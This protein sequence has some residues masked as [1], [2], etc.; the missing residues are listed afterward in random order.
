LEVI[1]MW[2]KTLPRLAAQALLVTALSLSGTN[3]QTDPP[4]V[5]ATI[6]PVHSLVAAVMKGIGVPTL[7]L[8]GAASPHT[9][10]LRPSDAR[11]LH[12]ARIIFWI[13]PSLEGFLTRSLDA[14]SG[15]ARVVTLL[16][17]PGMDL[18]AARGRHHDGRTGNPTWDPHLWLNPGNAQQ[19][20][21]LVADALV[22]EDPQNAEGYRRNAARAAARLDA[23]TQRI[24]SQFT[25]RPVAPF[26]LFHDSFQYLERA[27]GLSAAGFV[28]V[29]PDRPPGARHLGDIHALI[30]DA[31]A[32]CVFTEPQFEPRLVSTLVKGT[33]ARIAVLDALGSGLQAG[34]GLYFKMMENNLDAMVGCLIGP[35]GG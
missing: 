23:L 31:K 34:P 32:A 29:A 9:Y 4:L 17:A 26:I 10:A 20:V 35:G 1:V 25:D 6:P 15:K 22:S 28:T 14:L 8:N 16:Q 24:K 3:A 19:I 12:R 21:A 5:V 7:L 2:R 18:L 30:S 33:R 11:R 27:L 13:G